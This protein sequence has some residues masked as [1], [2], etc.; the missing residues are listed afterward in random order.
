LA[1]GLRLPGKAC[2]DGKAAVYERW[3]RLKGRMR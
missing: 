3:A 2:S 1:V